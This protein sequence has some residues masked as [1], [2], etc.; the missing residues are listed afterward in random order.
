ME[1]SAD[2]FFIDERARWRRAYYVKVRQKGDR[3]AG[4]LP[5]LRLL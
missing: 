1:G 4:A 5:A 2:G 3:R